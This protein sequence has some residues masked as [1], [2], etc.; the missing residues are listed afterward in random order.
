M[1]INCNNCEVSITLNENQ[2]QLIENLKKQGSTFG[3]LHCESCGLGFGVNPQDLNQI[4]KDDNELIWRSPISGSHGFVSY[5]SN[6]D[7]KTFYGCS[8][9]GV[10]WTTKNSFYKNI[11]AIINKYPH[12]SSFYVKIDGDWYPS[13]EEPENIDELIDKEDIEIIDNYQR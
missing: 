7:E 10:I 3:M 2:I 4:E 1:K 8:D 11:E 12:R 6:L 5:I 9:T 13:K